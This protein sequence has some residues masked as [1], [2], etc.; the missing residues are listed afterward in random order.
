[1]LVILLPQLLLAAVFAGYYYTALNLSGR[2]IDTLYALM[3]WVLLEAML[4]R[5]LA[6]AARR[7]AWQPAEARRQAEAQAPEGV[8]GAPG[9]VEGPGLAMEQVSQRSLRLIRR[10]LFAG[11]LAGLWWVWSDLPCVF[12]YLDT[13]T[14]Y[15][16]TQG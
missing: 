8:G 13:I 1:M 3:I 9:P 16:F 4:I 7:L 15:E 2:L 6:V 14:L 11:L 5:G 12:S 10:A